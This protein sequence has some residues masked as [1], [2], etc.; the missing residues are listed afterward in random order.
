MS[1]KEH[2]LPRIWMDAPS[3]IWKVKKELDQVPCCGGMPGGEATSGPA[4]HTYSTSPWDRQKTEA[5]PD[6]SC[7]LV[8]PKNHRSP[9]D[10]CKWLYIKSSLW[11]PHRLGERRC[12]NPIWGLCSGPLASTAWLACQA[13]GE[14]LM[15]WLSTVMVCRS[16]NWKQRISQQEDYCKSPF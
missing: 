7:L 15:L 11:Q 10:C 12:T 14:D 9:E 4:S 1:H 8:A 2:H 3:A 5:W 6:S 13:V 16:Y